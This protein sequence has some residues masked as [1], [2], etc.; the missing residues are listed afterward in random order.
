MSAT[1][2]D[3]ALELARGV[4]GGVSPNPAVGCVILKDGVVVGEG[5]NDPPGGP[6]AEIVALR[7][8]GD[9]ARGGVMYVTLEPCSHH[10]RTP[11]CADAVA[12][13]G[14]TAVHAAVRDPNS[15]VAGKGVERLR[16][17]GIEVIEG[18]GEKEARR[19]NEAFMK[20]VTTDLPFVYV[21][22]AMSLDGKI[23]T[24]AG[25][26]RW[27]TGERARAEAHR[28]RGLVDAVMVGA[29]T[30]RI[31][32]PRLTA[33]GG[34]GE[35]E[36]NARQPLR[37]VVD[38]KASLSSTARMLGEPGGT[39]VAATDGAPEAAGR[40]LTEAGAEVETFEAA[41]G[42]GVDLEALLRRLAK[43]DVTSVLV[44]G[45]GG[46]I[47][48]LLDARIVDKVIAFVAPVLVG[49]ADAPTPAAG[50]GVERIADALRLRG[51]ETSVLDGDVMITGYAGQGD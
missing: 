16:A 34:S 23:A 41:P 36:A 30:A 13:A 24:T 21:K 10:G 12:E 26:S 50:A 5:A 14:L 3:R 42:G 29:R 15:L 51:V 43:R 40:A 20:W 28:L 31:D 6:H 35:G 19:V 37:V 9:R 27:I 48:S 45:G 32:D 25:D 4:L 2:M 47:G 1:P 38:S 17:A 7:Q 22:F 49:G 8:A 44:E 46:L 33:R 11:P 39:L 18:E